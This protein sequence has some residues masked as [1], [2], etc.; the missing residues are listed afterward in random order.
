[1]GI[2]NHRRRGKGKERKT[3]IKNERHKG[4]LDGRCILS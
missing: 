2:L 4:E 3:K 1:M